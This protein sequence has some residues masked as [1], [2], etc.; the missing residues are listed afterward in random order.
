ML[1]VSV[2]ELQEEMRCYLTFSDENV[3]K[4]IAPPEEMSAIQ[5]E[6]DNPQSTMSTPV[7]TPEEEATVQTARESIAEERPPNRFPG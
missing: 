5:T 1:V 3:F 7:S 4:G 2:K 6:E